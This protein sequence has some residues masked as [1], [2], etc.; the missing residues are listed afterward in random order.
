M[1]RVNS[2]LGLNQETKQKHSNKKMKPIKII[3]FPRVSQF[4]PKL[5]I[6]FKGIGRG[7]SILYQLGNA[8]THLCASL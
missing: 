1:S 8:R 3:Q 4:L 2:Y 7:T 5:M 6:I